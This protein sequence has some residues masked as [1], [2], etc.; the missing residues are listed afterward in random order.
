MN[1][2]YKQDIHYKVE[3]SN[4]SGHLFKV[5]LTIRNP[6]PDGQIVSLPAWIPGSYMIRD[7]AKN[8]ISLKAFSKSAELPYQKLDKQSWQF[9]P[10]SS[11]IRIEYEVYAWDLSVRSAHLDTI[12]GYFNG[13]SLFLAVKG[14]TDQPCSVELIKPKQK[15]AI[16]WHVATTLRSHNP[17]PYSFGK[18][19]ATNYDDLIDHPVEMSDFTL[20]EFSA[21][22]IPHAMALTGHFECDLERLKHDLIKICEYEIK[23]FGDAPFQQYLFQ[24]MVVGNGYGGLEHRSS[25][26]LLCSRNDLPKP[27]IEEVTDEY[28]Q[29]LSL[30]SHEYFHS[31]N[32]KRIKPA[33][34]IPYDLSIESYTPLLW[35]FEGITS[36]Y[37]ELILVRCGVISIE[38]YLEM[39]GQNITRV[40]MGTGRDK[41]TVYESSFDA[42]IRFYKQDEN[43]PN[44]IVSYY[45]KGA[46]VALALDMI[47]HQVS[48]KTL[49]DIMRSLWL[50][51]GKPL[52]GVTPDGIEQLISKEAGVD[53][54]EFF[55]K[56]LR[57]TE[58]LELTEL[59]AQMGISYHLRAANNNGDKGGKPSKVPP[60]P[61]T[62]FRYLKQETGSVSI[63]I[64]LEDSPAQLA[65]LSAGDQLIAI[66]EIQVTAI[67]IERQLKELTADKKA[68]F[69]CFRRD[70][71]M[72]FELTP[73]PPVEN[74]CYLEVTNPNSK[75]LKRW[76]N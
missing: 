55:H 19:S 3:V 57:T 27:G 58:E 66:N 72:R 32:I 56:S 45:T 1:K 68:I 7:F 50:H 41:Q 20:I 4:P 14:Q 42:W 47:L 21:C 36:Y 61:Y 17:K 74:I 65:G 64:V 67:T 13:T 5:E 26:S 16:N 48:N 25:T 12:H 70:E 28:R 18:Y 29:F 9:A 76:L 34:F 60:P 59:F 54:S 40:L 63:Q 62:G 43:A 22:N 6:A 69:H 8:I 38:S 49:D 11:P 2:T 51:H 53:L 35:A 52:I 33:Q 73:A 39:L 44:A 10:T 30:C 23:L 75:L 46:M 31:W 37:D 24:V 71:L 15:Y